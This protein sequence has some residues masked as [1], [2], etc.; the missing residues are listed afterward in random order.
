MRNHT[1]RRAAL[2]ALAALLL[3]AVAA[4]TARGAA[5]YDRSPIHLNGL[6]PDGWGTAVTSAD[7]NARNRYPGIASLYCVGVI[8]NGWSASSSSWVHGLTRY[9]D[10]EACFG[11]TYRSSSLFA[12][13]YD[14]KSA[15]N[16][17]IFRLSGASLADLYG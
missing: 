9:W 12:F 11:H 14:T 7:R 3:V 4:G 13:V 5:A 10:K 8:M 6:T 16:W 2:V 15:S 1:G 17:T